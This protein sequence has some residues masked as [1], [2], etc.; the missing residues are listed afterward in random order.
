MGKKMLYKIT[1]AHMDAVYEMYARHVAESDL[2]GF[3]V[4][5]EFI[6]GENSTLVVD[7]AEER[8]KLEFSGVKRS[9]IPIQSIFRIDEV[10]KEGVVKVRDKTHDIN[11]IAQFPV[12]GK[13]RE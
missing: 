11:K 7:P 8:L 12:P 4:V 9:F 5:E 13:P 10:E 1:F 6:F 3:L 2:F